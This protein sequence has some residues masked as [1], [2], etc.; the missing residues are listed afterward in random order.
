MKNYKSILLIGPFPEPTTG[1]SLANQVVS[2]ILKGSSIFKVGIINTSYTRFDE[3][4]GKFSIH[5]LLFNLSFFP[6]VFRIFGYNS[7]YITP[8]QTFFGIVKYTFFILLASFLKKEL[9]IHVHGNHLGREYK[10]LKTIKKEIFRFLVSRFTKGIVLSTSLRE[11]LTPFL[12]EENIYVLPNFAQNYLL[13]TKESKDEEGLQIIYLSNLMQEKGIFDL[14]EALK[15]LETNNIPYQA[16]IA[17]AMDKSQQKEIEQYFENLTHTKYVGIVKG[18]RKKELLHWGNIFVLPTFY[19]M[20]GQPI[21][22]LEAMATKNVIITTAHAGIPDVVHDEENGF[23]VE[24]N[25]PSDIY[26]K[27]MYLKGHNLEMDRIVNHNEVYFQENF[28]REQ[29]KSRLLDILKQ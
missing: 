15:Q 16:R 11:N 8:G 9:I 21:S 22:I 5:K 2:D 18:D 23:F 12:K 1:V 19:K 14:L 7:I 27:L 13:D 20:E 10:S 4:I 29:F 25:N 24:K 3:A 26:D 17:G 6:K 28:T